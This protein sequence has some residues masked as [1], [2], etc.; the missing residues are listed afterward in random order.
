MIHYRSS[1]Y[2]KSHCHLLR[3]IPNKIGF[4]ESIFVV[5]CRDKSYP[6]A[7]PAIKNQLTSFKNCL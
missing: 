1:L 2:K 5:I 7:Q 3:K 4:K 6:K